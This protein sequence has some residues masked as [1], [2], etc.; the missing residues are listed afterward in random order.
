MI[1]LVLTFVFLILAVLGPRFIKDIQ[2][3]YSDDEVKSMGWARWLA[4]GLC[5]VL[6]VLAFASTSILYVDQDE[7]GHLNRIYGGSNMPASQVIAAPWQNGAQAR[8]LTPGFKFMPFVKVFYDIENKPLVTVP[9][10]SYGFLSTTDGAPL[11]EGQYIAD[12]WSEAEFQK[13]ISAEY[14]LGF[15]KG[16]DEFTG[17]RGQKGP[18]L[19]VLRPGKYRINRYLF[20]VK[21]GKSKDIEAGFVGVVKSNVGE[22]YHGEPILP[23]GVDAST[24]SVPIVPKGY[25]GVWKE[26]LTPG[27]YYMNEKAYHI[28]MVDT[29]VQTWKYLGGYERKWIDL[30]V[31][32]DGKIHQEPHSEVVAVPEDAADSAIVLRVDGWDVFQDSRVQVQ[33]T[34]D[35]APFVVA[36]VGG[37]TAVEDKII[38]PNYRSIL[39]NVVAQVVTITEPVID[40]D[41]NKVFEKVYGDDGN[42]VEGAKGEPKMHTV[43]RPR[44]VLDLLYHREELEAE[45]FK[46]LIP[47]ANQAGLT[48]QWVRFGDPAVPPSL[49]IPGKRKQLAESLMA[50]YKQEKRAQGERVETEKEKARA[51]QQGELMKSEIGIK[52]ADNNAMAREKQGLGEKKY[53][54]AV[55]KGQEAQA[56]VLGK[57]KTFELAYVKSILEAVEKNPD[58]VK[59][60]GTLVMGS[61]SGLTGAAALIGPNSVGMGM[62]RG[63]NK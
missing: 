14:F 60:P 45:V 43:T 1:L 19:A 59:Y 16:E 33:V 51:D 49:L 28:T 4:R 55:A 29:R 10:G 41:G 2:P 46:E 34:P 39:R 3:K 21:E 15:D 22:K 53:M 35:N 56:N 20:E 25:Q 5:V 50:T 62:G 26:V 13:M 47:T 63:L 57:D 38:T 12:D 18:Q 32:E 6:S 37:L 31:D 40:A 54:E 11:R 52:V 42:I 23:S 61:D 24:L 36:S 30:I 7:V 48:V 9:E 8:I 44:Q 27:R 58:I 17:A